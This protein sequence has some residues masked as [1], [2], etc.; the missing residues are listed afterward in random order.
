LG[1]KLAKL[2]IKEAIVEKAPRDDGLRVLNIAADGSGSFERA[3]EVRGLGNYATAERLLSGNGKSRAVVS[4]GPAGEMKMGA[5]SIAVN[6][7]EG[8]PTRHAARGG[9]G[10]R[11]GAKGLKANILDDGNAKNVEA[12]HKDSF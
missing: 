2:A 7:P 6:D 3:D 4:I 12:A 5:A 9:L 1:N 8:R 10:A 11:M